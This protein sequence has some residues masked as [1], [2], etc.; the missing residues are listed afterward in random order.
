MNLYLVVL[1]LVATA[2]PSMM[3]GRFTAPARGVTKTI[4]EN[5]EIHPGDYFSI[6]HSELRNSKIVV[7]DSAVRWEIRNNYFDGTSKFIMK[8]GGTMTVRSD[9]AGNTVVEPLME[10]SRGAES[11]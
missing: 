8:N 5:A 3:L 4:Y 10:G 1:L 11:P 6:L 9:E 2:V 7:P